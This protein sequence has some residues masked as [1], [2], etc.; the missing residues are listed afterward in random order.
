MSSLKNKNSLD[1]LRFDQMCLSDS[2]MDNIRKLKYN[3]PTYIQS[4]M[5][6]LFLEGKD[7]VCCSKTGS[8]KTAAY[9]IPMINKLEKHSEII[10]A[11]AL[12]LVPSRELAMQTTKKLRELIWGTDLR[13]SIIIGGHDY[14]GQ[15]DS[16]A[17][18]PDIVVATPG[19]VMEILQ[20]TQFT[21]TKV[22]YLII[23]EAD[24]LFEMGF[25]TQVREILKSVS[26]K[27][28]TILLSAT[29]PAELSLFASS[30]LRDYA[31]IKVDSEYKLPDKAFMHAFLCRPE[32]KDSLLIYTLQHLIR[33]N[34]RS[35]IFVSSRH[36]GD[37]LDNLLPNF[38]ITS[39]CIN[40]KMN[41]LD[42]NERMSMFNRKE[43]M[44]L[45]VTDLGARGLDLPFVKN[46]INFD[47]PQ[48][49]KLFIHR[50]GRTARADRTGSIFSFFTPSE[51][52][53]LAQIKG[54]VEREFTAVKDTDDYLYKSLYYGKVP[55]HIIFSGIECIGRALKDDKEL[56]DLQKTAL[57]SNE[58]FEKTRSK[59]EQQSKRL[60]S[61]FDFE[62]YHPLFEEHV[63]KDATDYLNRMKN[64]KPRT[65]HF[66]YEKAQ[67]SSQTDLLN[68]GKKLQ[69]QCNTFHKNKKMRKEAQE[70]AKAILEQEET[71][72]MNEEEE[73][74]YDE[75]ALRKQ[76]EQLNNKYKSTMLYISSQA[77]G[78]PNDLTDSM[79]SQNEIRQLVMDQTTEHLYEQRKFMWDE[80]KKSFKKK[81][82]G[83]DGNVVNED[84]KSISKNKVRTEKMQERY[85]N[86]KKKSVI[87]FQK[88][89]DREVASNTAKAQSSF[90]NRM[91][92]RTVGEQIKR[93]KERTKEIRYQKATK[94]G[95]KEGFMKGRKV[96]NELKSANQVAKDKMK[97]RVKTFGKGG[98]KGGPVSRGK[99][100]GR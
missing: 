27:R 88:V 1:V 57:N 9:M 61:E 94:F 75:E 70:E 41:Q 31:L 56:S 4:K 68:L 74:E 66:A 62:A 32:Q 51:R 33:E 44:N 54:K 28:Q 52:L 43:V 46:V 3:K 48:N 7:I 49:T 10:G 26:N 5:I 39:I 69:K 14:E 23:D 96:K 50:C 76:Q 83:I 77:S 35:I 64:Y 15:F 19:R 38:N 79:G 34:E 13:Y 47:F 95:K 40:G 100:L 67:Q 63:D 78:Q 55:E 30:G 73:E 65:S 6:P 86:W 24:M 36:W 18:N 11:R 71:Q 29:I 16:L 25:S 12:V 84:H 8:G 59:A 58:Q 22:Q 45:I 85:K 89:G 90:K 21:L 97:K 20:E 17:S 91:T 98:S 82:I 80:D 87:N 60:M 99:K 72:R 42:R 93:K 2:L 92:H 53:Y 81:K 37:Y